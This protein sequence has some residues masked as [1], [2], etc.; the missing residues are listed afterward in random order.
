MADVAPAVIDVWN[1]AT[2]DRDLLDALESNSELIRGY[3]DTANRIFLEHD[4]R[5]GPDRPLMRPS[6]P[7][8]PPYYALLDGI[9]QLMAARTIRAFHY[10]RLTDDE[11]SDIARSGIH[12]STPD[13]LRRRFD[14]LVARG[15]L[16]QA[17]AD[18]LYSHSPFHSDQLEG[19]SGKFWMTSHPISVEDHGVA[20]LLERWGGEVAS[21]WVA[22]DTLAAPLAALGKPR[23]LEIAVPLAATRHSHSAGTAVVATFGRSLGALPEKAAFDLYV[24]APLPASA[25][26]AVLTESDAAFAAVGRTYPAGYVDVD[27][28]R[29][30]ELTGED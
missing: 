5:S 18:E 6:N 21:F 28:G 30:K 12:L 14:A 8:A 7:L 22:D 3:I 2:F 4:L 25:V 26:I 13:S 19:R 27:V 11:A 16:P 1:T 29:W 20:P 15:L 24:R 23:V 10:T 9:D 17:M